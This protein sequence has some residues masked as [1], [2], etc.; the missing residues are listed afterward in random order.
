M[1]TGGGRWD[2]GS[3]AGFTAYLFTFYESLAIFVGGF[4][5]ANI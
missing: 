4:L 1:E 5:V 2:V 3:T